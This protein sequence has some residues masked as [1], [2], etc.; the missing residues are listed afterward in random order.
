MASLSEEM[1]GE[2]KE[3]QWDS[4]IVHVFHAVF[5][6]FGNKYIPLNWGKI[7]H[8]LPCLLLGSRKLD[9]FTFH[10]PHFENIVFRM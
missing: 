6:D 3:A 10:D 8:E 9:H 1:V 4:G 7:P 5:L 2:V